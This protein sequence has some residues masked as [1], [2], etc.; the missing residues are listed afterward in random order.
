MRDEGF[1]SIKVMRGRNGGCEGKEKRLED[2]GYDDD[3]GLGD[4]KVESGEE[5]A[6]S[7]CSL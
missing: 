4:E 6:Y 3:A 1:K 7:Y 2:R 5:A